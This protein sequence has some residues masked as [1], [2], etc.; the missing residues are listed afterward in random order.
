MG[1]VN[2]K[3]NDIPVKVPE[4]YTIL[5][6]AKSINVEIPSL[7]YLK[8]VNCIGACRVCVVEL[9]GHKGLVASCVYPVEEGMEVYT[10]TPAVRTS[11]K[12]TIELIL[13]S[14]HKKCLSCVRGNHCE[15]QKLAF[16][17]DVDE[18]RFKGE[19]VQYPIDNQSP[20]IV[21]DNNKCCLL[22]T[23]DAADD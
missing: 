4:G 16:D 10:N 18:D 19:D 22:Y 8:D 13:S 5:Q 15:L 7:C 1:E 21:R 2:L 20:Y 6:A 3:I 23:S 9:K 11:R 14:H 17:Y 12:T